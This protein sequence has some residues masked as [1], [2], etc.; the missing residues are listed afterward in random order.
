MTRRTQ[1]DAPEIA[2]RPAASHVAGAQALARAAA[3]GD[4][5]GVESLLAAGAFADAPLPSGETPLMRAA[6]RGFE[7]VARL[8]LGAGANASARRADGFTPLTLAAFFG[9]AGLVR[10]LLE[11]GAD[12]S[13]RT[14]LGTTAGA[15]ADARGFTEISGLIGAAS[16]PRRRAATAEQRASRQPAEAAEAPRRQ[17]HEGRPAAAERGDEPAGRPSPARPPVAGVLLA[18]LAPDSRAGRGGEERARPSQSELRARA[19]EVSEVFGPVA[20]GDAAT[21]SADADETTIQAARGNEQGAPPGRGEFA[22]PGGP[23]GAELFASL[24]TTRP[25]RAARSRQGVAGLLLLALACTV[26]VYAAWRATRPVGPKAGQVGTTQPAAGA[27]PVAPL[28]AAQPGAPQPSPGATPLDPQSIIAPGTAGAGA[29]V[30]YPAGDP[31][32]LP[33]VTSYPGGATASAPAV[34]T[35]EGRV[36]APETRREGPDAARDRRGAGQASS[37]ESSREPAPREDESRADSPRQGGAPPVISV[38]APR[39]APTAA[40][41]LPSPTP[42]RKVIQWPPS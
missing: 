7:D 18:A 16:D 29:F 10:L 39:P 4:C 3:A 41:P 26:G 6:A 2:A 22:P 37:D 11:H 19:S 17:D 34:V 40:E 30:P 14:R 21:E 23:G 36:A 8:L 32:A 12:A 28:P 15:W 9:H 25:A 5:A 31:V 38:P 24:Q 20:A 35:E 13:A 42:G 33:P 1:T 27:Q